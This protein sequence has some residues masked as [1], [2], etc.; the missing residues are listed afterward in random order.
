MQVNGRNE[1]NSPW[2]NGNEH[3]ISDSSHR[4]LPVMEI[5]SDRLLT[6]IWVVPR[7]LTSRPLLI[8]HGMGGFIIFLNRLG[9]D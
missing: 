1:M 6:V 5:K 3:I 7:E 9:V 2:S 8:M 4:I